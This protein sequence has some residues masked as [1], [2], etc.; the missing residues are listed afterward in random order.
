M[1][2]ETRKLIDANRTPD[3]R[4]ADLDYDRCAPSLLAFTQEGEAI[5]FSQEHG[6]TV[7]RFQLPQ[8]NLWGDSGS[9]SRPKL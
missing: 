3:K 7:L 2:V 5:Q 9:G 8:Q 1:C 6:G 4:P